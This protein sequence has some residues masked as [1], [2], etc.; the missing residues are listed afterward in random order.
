MIEI[1]Q[2]VPSFRGETATGPVS[3]TSL[4]GRAYVLYFYPKDDTP[5][6]TIEACTFRDNLPAFKDM[7]VDVYGISKDDL[8]AHQ[9][10]SE[11][12]ELPF[13]LISDTDGSMCDSFGTWVEK[14]MYGRTYMGIDRVTFL[15][16]SAGIVRYV[17]KKVSP[18]THAEEVLEKIKEIL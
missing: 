2:K 8:K 6:C 11:K 5:G 12:Y 13:T 1:G 7:G 16:D 9:K 10:F 3:D 18:K 15:I 4:L 14:S 17:W